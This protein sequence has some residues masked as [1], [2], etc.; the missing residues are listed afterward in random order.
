M[1]LKVIH[2]DDGTT[3]TLPAP[4]GILQEAIRITSGDRQKVYG[5]PSEDWTRTAKLWSAILGVE[6]TAQQCCLCMIAVKMSRLCK[7]P[8]H[9][10]SIVDICG[11]SRCI[12]LIHEHD[13]A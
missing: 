12:E 7:T 13:N 2:P 10:D 9:R 1:N 5:H 6:V 11:Y 3:E 4:E 8:G